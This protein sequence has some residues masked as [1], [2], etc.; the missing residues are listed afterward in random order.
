[1]I[2]EYIKQYPNDVQEKL[3]EIRAIIKGVIPESVE[4]ISY[5]MPT[6][7]INNQA[8]VYFAGFKSHIGFYPFPSGVEY[9]RKES[10]DYKTAKGSIQFPL[11][12]PLPVDLIKKVVQFRVDE[13]RNK[14]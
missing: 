5:K 14:V 6:F 8:V 2:D 9:F 4:T 13:L 7:K 11:D 3:Y 12:K 1:M 10:K